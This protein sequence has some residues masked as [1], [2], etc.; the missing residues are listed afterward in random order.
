MAIELTLRK[1]HH[2]FTPVDQAGMDAISDL[3]MNAEFK[4]VLTRP[5]NIRFHRKYFTLLNYAFEC[6]EP[7]SEISE[8]HKVVP[9]K[10][11]EQ[12]REDILILT[13]HYEITR[14]IDGAEIIKAKSISFAKMDDLEF[15]DVY[16][17][18]IDVILSRVLTQYTADD[19]D[20]IV[21]RLLA[22]YA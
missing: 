15:E 6:W 9:L 3:P 19:V 12:F 17:K 8:K 13:G 22:Q 14:R 11:R 16:S 10:S 1:L 21:N 5:R 20:D 2:T 4:A 7:A 18:T